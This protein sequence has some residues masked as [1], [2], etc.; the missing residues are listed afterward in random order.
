M[1]LHDSLTELP[2]R[3]AQ[4]RKLD[5]LLKQ[6]GV[7]GSQFA[8]LYLDLDRFKE[9]NDLFGHNIG[10]VVLLTAAKRLCVAADSAF[11]ARFGGD[12]FMV[13][14]EVDAASAAVLADRIIAT[15]SA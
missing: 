5:G 9:V 2:N 8:V 13:L 11:V 1:A 14:A 12:E 3:A 15:L 7:E 10:D 6:H 4:N